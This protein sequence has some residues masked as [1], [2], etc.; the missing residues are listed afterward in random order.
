VDVDSSAVELPWE[1]ISF[2]ESKK[3]KDLIKVEA[4]ILVQ[5]HPMLLD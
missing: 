4:N 3:Y 1:S 5:R 2:E